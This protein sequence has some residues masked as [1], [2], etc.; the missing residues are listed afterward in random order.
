MKRTRELFS[1][2]L[3]LQLPFSP[4]MV[5]LPFLRDWARSPA[6]SLL[7]KAKGEDT[8]DGEQS[9]RDCRKPSWSHSYRAV[10]QF[11]VIKASPS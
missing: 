7:R 1:E 10:Q 11:G 2:G 3:C 4:D 6:L 9:K 8:G 5:L